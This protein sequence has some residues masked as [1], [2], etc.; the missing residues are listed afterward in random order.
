MSLDRLD[1]FYSDIFLYIAVKTA[2]M[3]WKI[4]FTKDSNTNQKVI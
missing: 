2:D 3:L 1:D 4:T